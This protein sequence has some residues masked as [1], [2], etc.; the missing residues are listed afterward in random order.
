MKTEAEGGHTYTAD[1]GEFAVVGRSRAGR[2]G[3]ARGAVAL[4]VE[5]AGTVGGGGAGSART[6]DAGGT[7]GA[8]DALARAWGAADR[9]RHVA[10]GGRPAEDGALGTAGGCGEGN[11][12]T[13]RV[14][15]RGVGRV[16][17]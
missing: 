11:A 10:A 7:G 12:A 5:V 8:R 9:G 17:D 14:A 2:G 15:G 13:T 6:G 16:G 3:M 4:L 1:L